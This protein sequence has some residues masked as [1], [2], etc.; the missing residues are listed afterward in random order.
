LLAVVL[1]DRPTARRVARRLLDRFGGLAA[2]VGALP[3]ELEVAGLSRGAGARLAA[4]LEALPEVDRV[5]GRGLLLAAELGGGRPAPAA[6][7][8]ALQAGLVVNPVT[9]TALR[10]A[11]SLL[12][13]D[14]EIEEA[15]SILAGVLAG[16]PVEV[17]G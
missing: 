5:R 13:T 2:V 8:A 4:A 14:E 17:P 10:L 6:S 15:V 7:T 16:T 1:G 11:P 12:V 3:V 9:P